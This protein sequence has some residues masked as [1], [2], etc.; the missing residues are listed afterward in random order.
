MESASSTCWTIAGMDIEEKKM[1]LSEEASLFAGRMADSHR[2]QR[3]RIFVIPEFFLDS[4]HAGSS[5]ITLSHLFQNMTTAKVQKRSPQNS[6]HQV[7]EN[8]NQHHI[9]HQ[10]HSLWWDVTKLDTESIDVNAIQSS[11]MH[12]MLDREIDDIVTRI[13]KV[14]VQ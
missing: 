8:D 7:D 12:P 6:S 4:E 14:E 11:S 5:T 10:L 9:H 1:I 3:G 2:D 13:A